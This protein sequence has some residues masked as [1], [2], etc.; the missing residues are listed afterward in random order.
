MEKLGMTEYQFSDANYVHYLNEQKITIKS[1]PLLKHCY[2]EWYRC[3]KKDLNSIESLPGEII[4]LGSG[5][6]FLGEFVPGLITSDV[7][8]GVADR[9][10]KAPYLPL[11]DQSVKALILVQVFHH[12]PHVSIFLKECERVLIPGG[13]LLILDPAHTPLARFLLKNFH[14]EP[15]NDRTFE[16]DFE[17]HNK[18]TDANQANSW[19]IFFRDSPLFQKKY[20][21]LFLEKITY[22]RWLSYILTGGVSGKNVIP[23]FLT[24]A[25]LYFEKLL[26]PLNKIG[27]LMWYLKIKKCEK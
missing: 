7:V 12:I 10:M 8:E 2:A 5:G 1:K 6:G 13:L 3:I 26:N 25:F 27:S 23:R 20:P 4:E 22:F 24:K 17:S 18:A 16:W 21:T 19:N 14:T 11:P 9:T 15:Y